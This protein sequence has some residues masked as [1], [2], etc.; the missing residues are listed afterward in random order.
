MWIA[1]SEPISP[2]SVFG[3]AI[4]RFTKKQIQPIEDVPSHMSLVFGNKIVLEARGSGVRITYLNSFLKKNRVIKGFMRYDTQL[5]SDQVL[6]QGLD[7]FYGKG[8]D[9]VAIFWW[10]IFILRLRLFGIDV[11]TMKAYQKD[12]KFYCSELFQLTGITEYDYLDPNSQ[13]LAVE[14]DNRFKQVV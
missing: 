5:N 2:F 10:C 12:H 1:Y 14:L 4:K 11:P 13:M 9:F 6:A 7:A 3:K 8:Y